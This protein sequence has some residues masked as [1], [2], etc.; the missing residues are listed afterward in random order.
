MAPGAPEVAPPL[1]APPP[2]HERGFNI[3]VEAV[4]DKSGA[5]AMVARLRS[6]GYNAEEY[7]TTLGGQA[8]FRVRVG[9]YD[10]QEEAQA[11]Q[12]RL[13]DQYRSAYS[14]SR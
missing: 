2:R 3:Q 8:W 7:E 11:A 13:R 6:L 5:D 12:A 10:T 9:P 4:M 1:P 14:T